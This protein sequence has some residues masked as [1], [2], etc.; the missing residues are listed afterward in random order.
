[1]TNEE[2]TNFSKSGTSPAGKITAENSGLAGTSSLI[3]PVI[4]AFL[5]RTTIPSVS[6]ITANRILRLYLRKPAAP[7][8]KQK[9]AVSY[10]GRKY[11]RYVIIHQIIL[12]ILP[13]F[14][15]FGQEKLLK[16]FLREYAAEKQEAALLSNFR[17]DI[18]TR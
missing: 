2:K 8:R 17:Y 16:R 7:L 18:H 6:P 15:P 12:S 11:R 13:H 9:I 10:S 5:R 14:I 1:M 3:Q 4:T